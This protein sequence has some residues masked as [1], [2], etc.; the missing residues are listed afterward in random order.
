[1]SDTEVTVE[2]DDT[3]KSIID[4]ADP[5]CDKITGKGRIWQG[6]LYYYYKRRTT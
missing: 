1:M 3:L 2:I 4:M 5:D 6:R